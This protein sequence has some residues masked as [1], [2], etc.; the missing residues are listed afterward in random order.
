MDWLQVLLRVFHIVPGIFWGGA[1]VF[2]AHF[3]APAIAEAGPAGGQVMQGLMKRNMLVVMPVTAL[4][5]I[6]SGIGLM[7]RASEGFTN[8]FMGSPMGITLS[9]GGTIA[10]VAFLIGM[11][12]ARPNQ[13]KAMAIGAQLATMPDGPEKQALAARAQ[14]HRAKAFTTQKAVAGLLGLVFIAMAV[15]RYV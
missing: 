8:Q 12:V 7:W 6:L 5:T 3:L 10:V 13:M 2:A 11:F 4:V 1:M 9:I 14:A 15:A